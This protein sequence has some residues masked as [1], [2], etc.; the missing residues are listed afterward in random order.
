VNS[1]PLSLYGLE[2]VVNKLAMA[3]EWI[4]PQH[5]FFEWEPKDEPFCRK[6]GIGHKGPMKPAAYQVGNTLIV[7]PTIYE[8]LAKHVP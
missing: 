1:E 8:E 6:Y 3:S 2:I 5:R 4:F 7:H